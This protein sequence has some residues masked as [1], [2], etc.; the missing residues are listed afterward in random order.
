M[1]ER[2]RTCCRL[3]AALAIG[4]SWQVLAWTPYGYG[5][6]GPGYQ[7][8]YPE[9]LPPAPPIG[10]DA[11]QPRVPPVTD[12]SSGIGVRPIHP[13][14]GWAP[15]S[16]WSDYGAPMTPP[17]R[18]FPGYRS[19]PGPSRGYAGSGARSFGPPP[20]FRISRATSEDAYTVTIYLEGVTP[21]EIQVEAR[22]QWIRVSRD[23]SAQ[24]VQ[25]DSFDDGRGFMRSFS[26]S[27]G[28]SSRRLSVPRDGDLTAMSRDDGEKSIRIRIPRHRR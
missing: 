24:S 2:A 27:T 28:T 21:E 25:E 22:G 18:E 16:P 9:T 23:S 11:Y 13:Y 3:V 17:G 5:P 26:Y 14:G 7:S 4:F 12:P 15:V 20:G 10:S 19:A 8:G 1:S 6:Y